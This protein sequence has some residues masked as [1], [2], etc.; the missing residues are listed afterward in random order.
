MS[1]ALAWLRRRALGLSVARAKRPLGGIPD[2]TEDRRATLERIVEA[3]VLGYDQALAHDR[4]DRLAG[5]LADVEARWRG[6]AFEGAGMAL[7]LLDSLSLGR[8]GRWRRFQSE[9]A[10]EHAYLLHVG[11]GWALA[12]LRQDWEE[13]TEGMDPLLRWLVLD[14][15]GFHAGFFRP[16]RWHRDH[17]RPRLRAGAHAVFDQGLGRSLWFVHGAMAVRIVSAIEG[18]PR[19]RREDLWSGVGLACTYA[20]GVG[21]GEAQHLF[22][23][24]GSAA[25][26]FAQG[27][28]F[29][30]AARARGGN[31]AHHSD[32][33]CRLVWGRPSAEVA[34]DVERA[35]TRAEEGTGRGG[36]E[37][38]RADLRARFSS[39]RVE[40][41]DA[42]P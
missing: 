34:A 24:S 16:D 5:R 2:L 20:G 22:A 15:A 26:H 10:P 11:A 3:F 41:C 8:G 36:Y 31:P 40:V 23:A 1:G 17:E 19:E 21:P 39:N 25:P 6:F 35:R 13:R 42:V 37:R 38:W 14:G 9:V 32:E 30:V 29:A 33:V 18:F 4:L 12:R 27:V 7:W 28:A